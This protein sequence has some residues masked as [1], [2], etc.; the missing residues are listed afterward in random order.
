MAITSTGYDSGT[1]V[2][3]LTGPATTL[4]FETVIKSLTYANSDQDP[5]PTASS[6]TVKVNDGAADSPTPP[7]PR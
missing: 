7:P 3:T 4:Q 5:D 6:V 2:L 1:G